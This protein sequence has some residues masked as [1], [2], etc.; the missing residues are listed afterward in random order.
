MKRCKPWLQADSA[1]ASTSRRPNEG[2][3]LAEALQTR[4]VDW[5]PAGSRSASEDLRTNRE[6][7]RR[8]LV[9]TAPRDCS[10]PAE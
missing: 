8:D 1:Y 9:V 7:E 10:P 6:I 3:V 2:P 5:S 4:S